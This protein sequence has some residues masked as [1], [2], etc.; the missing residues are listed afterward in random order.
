[1]ALD[2]I[3]S[4]EIER[5]H[6]LRTLEALLEG[7]ASVLVL[8]AAAE[9]GKTTLLQQ[10]QRRF[11]A[12]CVGIFLTGASR[13]VYHPQ[14]VLSTII[15]RL[16]EIFGSRYGRDD[17][18][19]LDDVEVAK[20]YGAVSRQC[21]REGR[22]VYILVDGI[23]EIPDHGDTTREQIW[24]CLPVGLPGFK[25]IVSCRSAEQVEPFMNRV[26][27][28]KP[29][30]LPFL[31]DSETQQLLDGLGLTSRQV[32]MA[33]D[34]TGGVPGKVA[35]F[36]RLVDAGKN[37]EEL[38][39]NIESEMPDLLRFEWEP[40]DK[41]NEELMTL[42]AILSYENRTYS[43]DELS[44]IGGLPS[45]T[46]SKLLDGVSFVERDRDDYWRFVSD[47]MRRFIGSELEDLRPR[48]NDLLIQFHHADPDNSLALAELPGYLA[49]AERMVE[50]V[51][52]LSPERFARMLQTLPSFSLV[53]SNAEQGIH[54][55]TELGEDADVV[56]FSLQRSTLEQM[57]LSHTGLR[58]ARARVAIG[59]EETALALAESVPHAEMRL[60]I[61]AAIVRTLYDY[62]RADDLGV[63]QRVRAAV[64]AADLEV[65]GDH[66]HR[67]AADL[68]PVSPELAMELVQR[69]A[70]EDADDNAL[71]W[72]VARLAVQAHLS[73][74]GEEARE[75]TER[76]G[77]TI[78][79][80]A[81][82]R[83]SMIAAVVL[84][85]LT[86]EEAISESSKLGA[87]GDQLFILQ[88][89]MRANRDRSDASRVLEYGL[90]RAIQSST[91]S[92]NAQV[93]R[94]L[95]LCLPYTADKERTF[96][97][98]DLI[99]GQQGVLEKLGP[100]EDAYRLRLIAARAAGKWDTE[101][102]HERLVATFD[103]ICELD[104]LGSRTALYARLLATVRRMA[105]GQED[106]EALLSLVEQGLQLGINELYE[107]TAL[108]L[109][110]VG[111][112]IRALAV[113]CPI[114]A[115]WV[116]EQMNTERRRDEGYAMFA[117]AA[118]DGPL[119]EIPTDSIEEA[120]DRIVDLNTRDEAL[121]TVCH[122][123]AAKSPGADSISI[124]G[125]LFGRI[126]TL[127][128]TATR[129]VLA[130]QMLSRLDLS[131]DSWG[132]LRQ[133]L[134]EQ[135]SDGWRTLTPSH[136]KLDHGYATVALLAQKEPV[137][138]RQI[139][140]EVNML[141][142]QLVLA[143]PEAALAATVSVHL[144]IRAF[145][146]VAGR[147]LEGPDDIARVADVIKKLQND[148]E[149][150]RLFTEWAVRCDNQGRGDL[151]EK[152]VGDYLRPVIDIYEGEE[153]EFAR[154]QV[155][156][157]GAPA[158]FLAGQSSSMQLL[159]ALSDSARNEALERIALTL[160]RG[161]PLGDPFEYRER[162]GREIDF[163]TACQVVDVLKETSDDW[164]IF[165]IVQDLVSCIASSDQTI[166]RA[167]RANLVRSIQ[168]SVEG[169]LPND[170]Q[171][172]HQGYQ[173]LVAAHVN[174]LR[175]HTEKTP[176]REF[177]AQ[178][179]SIP[180]LSDKAFV[181]AELAG[182]EDGSN[183]RRELLQEAKGLAD[184]IPLID[185]R[186]ARYQSIA[187]TA[188]DRDPEFWRELV[189]DSIKL[190]YLGGE[191]SL[192]ERRRS[193]I[194]SAYRL[195]P[196]FA[197][198][199]ATLSDDDPA[200]AKIRRDLMRR[201]LKDN[202]AKK[203]SLPEGF[204]GA[205][206]RDFSAAAWMK[207]GAL[208]AKRVGPVQP[209]RALPL[210]QHAAPQPVAD[211]YPIFAWFIENAVQKRRGEAAV[212]QYVLPLFEACLRGAELALRAGSE[213]FV[214]RTEDP[215]VVR[216]RLGV[217]GGV[218][219][220]APGD[221]RKAMDTLRD[222]L[223]EHAIGR[224]Q[225]V[226][227]YFKPD[228]MPLLAMVRDTVPEVKVQVLTGAEILG[229]VK[230]PPDREYREAWERLRDDE[231]PELS[232]LAVGTRRSPKCPIHDRWWL[233]GDRGVQLGTS[234]G[235]LG[236]RLSTIRTLSATEVG[237]VREEI[238]PYF[239]RSAEV[240]N[241]SRI[242][243]FTFTV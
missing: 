115:M 116:I 199:L 238:A 90:Q 190:S 26:E 218:T 75:Y 232:I 45:E 242:T 133:K 140:D 170:S 78:T 81:A 209:D 16:A 23:G 162:L 145:A 200:S 142:Q 98:L 212:R 178:A 114:Q 49:S 169:K 91:Y 119:R 214:G 15:D 36:R 155:L 219:V 229:R 225:I 152:I 128:D 47:P 13:W 131:E 55:A 96:R 158:L 183:V 130:A 46:A 11:Q 165:R 217:E 203:R 173:I 69:Q 88:H 227:P 175:W 8:E 95:A 139:V 205:K 193:L 28:V 34:A 60:R 20:I 62:G 59:D 168:S 230:G 154:E 64:N 51:R 21:E 106:E 30:S 176:I 136:E 147:N 73:G 102:G 57:S 234:T 71:D 135:V 120:L 182:L 84:G 29:F 125:P 76:F 7:D 137:L 112:T 150:V 14:V 72:A 126:I 31:A 110:A 180:N 37:P 144:A 148:K 2:H 94:D 42:L 27:R 179:R 9:M 132:G 89:W 222:W 97:I 111:G 220:I 189:E 186:L 118:C 82:R 210:L 87:V 67:V 202:I 146:G 157:A 52:F 161:V 101:A 100:I 177:A 235:G 33:V 215:M 68:F 239:N 58:E 231:L 243:Y 198:S 123:I 18:S 226:D 160:C 113:K 103:R 206:E 122:R 25:F 197:A 194:N 228:D 138:A 195:D 187:S 105:S 127:R 83:L 74:Q 224:L 240:H 108:H 192:A 213:G 24:D 184:Q 44:R 117:T 141:K 223:A 156:I 104:D 121:E 236:A 129:V 92:I 216:G 56:R 109:E 143:D 174:R 6:L 93:L 54:A 201:R 35:V 134:L 163:D 32:R 4:P 233:S 53:K 164:R 77:D 19:K 172:K 79:N 70:A 211:S 10:F 99:D 3:D 124:V 48:V 167:Q 185:E 17:I 151:S 191:R 86:A 221:R 153:G 61:L 40:V 207:L 12:E 50:L 22:F 63:M 204:E 38:L 5:P 80:R 196:D 41:E 181:L 237:E 241:G 149:Q 39:N 171:I 85:G 188:Q 43:D 208:N 159:R 107:G 166:K 65:L 66:V 1:M